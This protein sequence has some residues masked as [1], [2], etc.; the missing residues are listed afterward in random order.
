MLLVIEKKQAQGPRESFKLPRT[1]KTHQ[2]HSLLRRT[3]PSPFPLSHSR[4][5]G[6]PGLVSFL[7]WTMTS[8]LLL[9][10]AVRGAGVTSG[11]GGKGP[12]TSPS[13]FVKEIRLHYNKAYDYFKKL[14]RTYLSWEYK[15]YLVFTEHLLYARLW[16][17]YLVH[18]S[19]LSSLT[20]QTQDWYSILSPF[21][22]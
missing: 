19:S 17:K 1:T 13:I 9:W 15:Q 4:T 7:S 11:S 21:Y 8:T 10:A 2:N 14:N 16:A 12:I 22:R 6:T 3:D 18:S 20:T 5:C